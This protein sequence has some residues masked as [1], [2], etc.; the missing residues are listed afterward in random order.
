M[1]VI[2]KFPGA[3]CWISFQCRDGGHT[4]KGEPFDQVVKTLIGHDAFHTRVVAVGVNCTDPRHVSSLLNLANKVNKWEQFPWKTD[5]V[6][7][8][9]VVYPNHGDRWD[10]EKN[11]WDGDGKAVSSSK[12][13]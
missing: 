13:I 10:A 3:Q 4:A 9:Y 5:Y 1:N 2:S 11:C 8:P 7:V 6:K 12:L